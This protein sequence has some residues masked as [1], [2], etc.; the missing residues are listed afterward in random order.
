[1][2][3]AG[4]VLGIVATVLAVLSLGWQV[5][6]LRLQRPRPKLTAVVGRLT[7]DGLVTND[8]S[9]EVRESLVGAAEQAD[10]S[11]LIIGVKV[12]NA[13]RSSFHVAGWAIRSEHDGNSLVPV[14]KPI[15]GADV[16]HD[17]AP[18]GSAVF[19]TELAHAHRFAA[20]GEGTEDGTR[21]L[22][23]TVSSGTRTYTTKPVAPELFSTRDG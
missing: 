13:G 17:V 2:S 9:A 4:L 11:P 5:T 14:E 22:V 19:L 18:G 15:A 1:M 20:A 6:L 21:R 7:R 12:I 3:V 8:A 23:L 10:E 16:P